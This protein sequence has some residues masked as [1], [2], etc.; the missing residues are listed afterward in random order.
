MLLLSSG[1]VL[2]LG[3]KLYELTLPLLLY[4]LTHSA[5][6]MSAMRSIEFLPN[7]LLAVF[8]GVLVDRSRKKRWT[9]LSVFFQIAVL[10]G[11]YLW[12]EKGPGASSLYAYYIGG[13]LLMTFGYA[14]NNA[15]AALVKQ[16]LPAGL[17]APANA[18]YS[19]MTTLIG[20][21]GPALTGLI[22]SLSDLQ[23][24]L[25]LT[26]AAYVPALLLLS[27]LPADG[28]SPRQKPAGWGRELAEA[29]RE[30][31]R[32]RALWQITLL[33][34]FMNA[35]SGMVDATVIFTAKDRLGLSSGMLGLALSAAGAGGLAGS[36]LLPPLKRRFRLGALLAASSLLSAAGSLLLALAASTGMMAAGLFVDGLAGA[37]GTICI[38]TYRQESTPAHLIGRINGL[39]GS[40]F[41]LGMPLA[42]Y[43]GGWASELGSTA[44][45]FLAAAFIHLSTAAA[46]R[47]GSLWKTA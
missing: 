45:V 44:H 33:V 16:C 6:A 25:L 2:A 8:I 7:L 26:A 17:L 22:L 37:V 4:D 42:I 28:R 19:F 24:G 29:W 46:C 23:D 1:F 11:L 40:I 30:L 31:R 5:V 14:Y 27:L 43:A 35:A 21:G 41:K 15:R 34:V 47:T 36:L 9:I 12:T 3:G 13:F 38:W 32:N 10:A 18:S 20:I 39:T